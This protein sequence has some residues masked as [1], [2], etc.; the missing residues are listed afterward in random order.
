[1][2]DVFEQ[3]RMS[4]PDHAEQTIRSILRIH[5][6][7][8]QKASSTQRLVG[9]FVERLGRP[10]FAVIFTL[11][12][13]S[14]IS[15]NLLAVALGYEPLDPVPF[16]A[17]ESAVSLFSLFAVILI[18]GAQ[19]HE[20]QLNKDRDLLALE[21]A[22]LSE[23]K[24]A[25][26]IQLLEELRR[27]SPNIHDRVDAAAERMSEPTDPDAVMETIKQSSASGQ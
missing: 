22:L 14:W 24:T 20:D 10:A 26:V 8:H 12:A 17:L 21:L 2:A 18:L 27:D 19:R 6:E 15:A 3:D 5:S 16:P 4:S 9:W 7:H 25:K 23:Q 13:F 11:V 1:L